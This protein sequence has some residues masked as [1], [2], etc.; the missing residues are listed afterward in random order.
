M[1]VVYLLIFLIAGFHIGSFL[2]V[3]AFRVPRHESFILGSSHCD[4]CNHNLKWYEMIPIFSYI[5]QRGQCKHCGSKIP[6]VLFISEVLTGILFLLSFYIFGFTYSLL[7]AL[8]L[9]CFF[10]LVLVSDTQYLIIPDSFII[11]FSIYFF[12]R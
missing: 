2:S 12:R 10:I 4:S 6:G 8:G 5:L 7:I 3:I 11:F 9:V 1:Y